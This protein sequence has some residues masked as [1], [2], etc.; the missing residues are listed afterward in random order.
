MEMNTKFILLCVLFAA[1][2]CPA[3]RAQEELSPEE[4]E[5][6][7]YEFIEKEVER[8]QSLLK[9][10]DWQVFYADSILTNNFKAMQEEFESLSKR[11]VENSALYEKA[12]DKW[13]QRTYDAFKRMLDEEQWKKYLKSGAEREQKARDKRKAKEEAAGKN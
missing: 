8:Y 4:K 5:K 11:R 10:E 2:F 7:F 1:L 13:Q 12:R 9:L 6:K 3:V